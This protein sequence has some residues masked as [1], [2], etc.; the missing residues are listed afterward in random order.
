MEIP[1][2]GQARVWMPHNLVDGMA[3]CR[4]GSFEVQIQDIEVAC[5][6]LKVVKWIPQ[7]HIDSCRYDHQHQAPA[8]K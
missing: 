5:E 1:L 6:G 8:D 7:S 4:F 3:V 2:P